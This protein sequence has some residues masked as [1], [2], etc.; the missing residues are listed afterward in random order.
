MNP[1]ISGRIF[2][3]LGLLIIIGGIIILINAYKYHYYD[4]GLTA[5]LRP[6]AIIFMFYGGLVVMSIGTVIIEEQSKK[7]E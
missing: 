2:I 1:K 4:K 5:I 3:T 6:L 7:Y